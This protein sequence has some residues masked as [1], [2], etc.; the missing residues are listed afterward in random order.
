MAVV[1]NYSG[2]SSFFP[3]SCNYIKI[4]YLTSK[5][6]IAVLTKLFRFLFFLFNKSYQL[7][8]FFQSV[9]DKT[10][11][12]FLFVRFFF[13]LLTDCFGMAYTKI[14]MQLKAHRKH[15]KN[16]VVNEFGLLLFTVSLVQLETNS[17]SF[18]SVL[19]THPRLFE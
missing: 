3:V 16:G 5:V 18:Q 2:S 12:Y 1:L 15:K 14:T 4:D 10:Y 19:C 9:A 8:S 6:L 17:K 11:S 13:L 7:I